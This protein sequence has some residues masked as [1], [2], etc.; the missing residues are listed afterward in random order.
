RGARTEPAIASNRRCDGAGDRAASAD[1]RLRRSVLVHRIGNARHL[2]AGAADAAAKDHGAADP[3]PR[4]SLR[5]AQHLRDATPPRRMR[6]IS[7]V[8]SQTFAPDVQNS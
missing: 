6:S 2:A 5:A 3:G 1:A 8:Y 7:K 4:V